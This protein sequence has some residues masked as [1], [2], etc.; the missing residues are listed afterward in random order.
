[1]PPRKKAAPADTDS[2]AI[3]DPPTTR[4]VRSS[5]RLASQAIAVATNSNSATNG[6]TSSKPASKARTK[7][8]PKPKPGSKTTKPTSKVGSKRGKADTSGDEDDAPASKRPKTTTVDEGEEDE[9]V[10]DLDNDKKMVMS[11]SCQ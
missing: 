8:A 10:T 7:A 4:T 6:T 3:Q 1:M 5:S 11:T 2:Q 9:D